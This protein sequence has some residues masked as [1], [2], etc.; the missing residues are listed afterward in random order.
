MSAR[1]RVLIVDGHS[2]LHAAPAYR[3]L[4]ATSEPAARDALSRDLASL[5]DT[6]DWHVVLVFDGNRAR[7]DNQSDRGGM[8]VI[9]SSARES[10]DHVIEKLALRHAGDYSII[11]A[12]NDRLVLTNVLASGAH[13][14][15]VRGLLEMLDH[16][17]ARLRQSLQRPR[18]RK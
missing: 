18:G 14:I 2:V 9:Y 1:P 6:S 7:H 11:V 3:D 17:S 4:L 13:S 5:H 12:S 8:Q 15:S 16:E 10:A